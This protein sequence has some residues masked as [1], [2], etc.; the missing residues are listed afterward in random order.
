MST[1]DRGL[2]DRKA[3]YEA[4]A[5][6]LVL[7]DPTGVIRHANT[8]FC[9]W[10]GYDLT[11]L[12][13]RLRIQDLLTVGG[14]IFHQTHWMP[15]LRLQG[16]IA[17]VKLDLV[18]RDGKTLPFVF[19]AVSREHG[20][21]LF[22]ELAVFAAE[23][24]HRYERELMISRKRAEEL[25][26]R[27]SEAQQALAL[28]EA[29]L[30]VAIETAKLHIWHV[31]PVTGLRHYDDGVS[32]LLGLAASEAISNDR[33]LSHVD[34]HD[35]EYEA[36]TFA[37]A[38]DGPV[39]AYRCVY[40]LNGADG[41][42]RTVRATGDA[43]FAADG[44]LERFVGVLQDISELVRQQAAAEDRAQFAEQMI[45]IASHDLRTPLT[46]IKMGV[47]M[48]GTE[49]LTLSRRGRIAEHVDKSADRA[50]RLVDDLLDFTQAKIGSGLKMSFRLVDIH[51]LI[52]EAVSELRL[53]YPAR[54]IAHIE[55]GH[56]PSSMDPDRLI[57]LLGNL[58]ANAV[59]Y[60]AKDDAV[61]VT[62]RVASDTFAIDVHNMGPPIPP[63]LLPTLFEPMTRGTEVGAE[64]RSVGLG[65]FIVREIARA[66]GGDITATSSLDEGTTFRAMFPRNH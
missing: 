12:V 17:E 1:D 23:D 52:S 44:H 48:L 45:G 59:T 65:L 42:Q 28:A 2:P 20:G 13:D 47:Q 41:M 55:Q 11:E 62:S 14:R 26:A 43:V 58:V 22:H 51:G 66:H 18:H 50:R 46:A 9:V 21:T 40:R 56:G 35:R 24:R 4:A 38:L 61:T 30:R 36:Q 64:N 15:L 57:Q 19:N 7:T 54:L 16:S 25:L 5:C 27:Q 33:Y 10:L 6:G 29:R 3:L 49:E 8:T 63:D 37:A 32:A 53:A 60:G 31:D 39:G 34:A